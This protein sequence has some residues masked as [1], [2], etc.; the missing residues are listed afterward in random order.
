VI[1]TAFLIGLTLVLA[2]MVVVVVRGIE[3]WRRAKR[4]GGAITSELARF[5]ERSARAEQLLAE[6]DRASREL[7]AATERLR[8]SRARLQVLLD[9]LEGAQRR[10]RW[11]RAFL[12][13]R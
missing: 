3:L 4:S 13:S 11:L 6:A 10:T 9:S 8:L 7:Q 1:L 5:E 12:P 2:G